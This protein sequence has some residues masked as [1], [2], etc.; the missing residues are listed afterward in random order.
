[1]DMFGKYKILYSGLKFGLK[2]NKINTNKVYSFKLKLE[3]IL[4][5]KSSNESM[6]KKNIEITILTMETKLF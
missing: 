2:Y 1:M 5:L 3:L 6:I 4:E